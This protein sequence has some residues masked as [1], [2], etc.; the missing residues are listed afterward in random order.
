[1]PTLTCDRH[2]AQPGYIVCVHII[3][4][5]VPPAHVLP[6]EAGELGEVLC[7]ACHQ[8]APDVNLDHLKLICASCVEG[9][10]GG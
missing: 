7:L 3:E 5:R 8:Q 6:A 2:G 10:I 4:R 9:I 1:M